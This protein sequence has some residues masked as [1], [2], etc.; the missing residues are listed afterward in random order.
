MS[1]LKQV[2][3][4]AVYI[5]KVATYLNK[6]RCSHG[7]RIGEGEFILKLITDHDGRST[8]SDLCRRPGFRLSLES[9]FFATS[10]PYQRR[11]VSGVTMVVSSTRA[12]R[13]IIFCRCNF[14]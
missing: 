8:P 12:S 1:K 10:S 4:D 6:P 3:M 7:V 14:A 13:P 2:V 5:D 9:N 11:I